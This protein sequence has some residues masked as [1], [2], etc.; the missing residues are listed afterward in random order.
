MI[1]SPVWLLGFG[2]VVAYSALF[3][4]SEFAKLT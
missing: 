3:A 1:P 2:G 4:A